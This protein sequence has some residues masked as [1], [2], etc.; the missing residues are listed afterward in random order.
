MPAAATAGAPALSAESWPATLAALDI[1]G[2]ARQLASNCAF[3]ARE[4]GLVRLRLDPAQQLL[5]T[6]ALVERLAQA[7]SRLHGETLRVEVDVAPGAVE[8][9][10]RLESE[11]A[12]R[13][14]E[15]AREGLEADPTVRALRERLGAT[16]R[17]DT[18]RA[19]R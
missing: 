11:E 10:A 8:T 18:V 3:V 2:A 17:P 6:P 15:V 16:L 19:P 9:P 14:V 1:G 5:R 13:R 7:L 4:G 12:A